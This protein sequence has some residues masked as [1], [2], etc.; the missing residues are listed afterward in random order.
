MALWNRLTKIFSP[1]S[2]TTWP[3]M[4]Q[5]GISLFNHWYMPTA[6][7]SIELLEKSCSV[8][9][10]L[11]TYRDVRYHIRRCRY[12]PICRNFPSLAPFPSAFFENSPCYEHVL[13]KHW[14]TINHVP[15]DSLRSPLAPY[16]RFYRTNTYLLI[17]CLYSSHQPPV[18]ITSQAKS[19]CLKPSDP[20][21]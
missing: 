19:Y 3:S 16:Q 20:S 14:K 8:S 17:A 10:F 21:G 7:K 15:N 18:L 11:V 1:V 5:T 9:C 2:A 4:R 6:L 12:Q 13:N